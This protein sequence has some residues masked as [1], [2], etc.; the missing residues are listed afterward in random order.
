MGLVRSLGEGKADNWAALTAGKSGIHTIRR[1]PI[2]NLR[3]TIAGTIDFIPVEPICAPTLARE[4]AMREADEAVG[5]PG[6]GRKGDFPGELFVAAPPMQLHSSP[7]HALA[8]A[9][10][11]H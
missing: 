2:D 6:L 8:Y 11:A 1:F 9:P 7:P 10:P 4:F 5:Q 3:T